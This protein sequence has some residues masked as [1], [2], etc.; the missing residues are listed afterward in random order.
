MHPPG[1]TGRG[2]APAQ[3]ALETGELVAP[4][5]GPVSWT[6]H[7]DLAEAAAAVLTESSHSVLQAA[8]R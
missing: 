6:T 2:P 7:A 8:V 4:S 1:S 3:R 5:D